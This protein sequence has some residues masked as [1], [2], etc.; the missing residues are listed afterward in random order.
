MKRKGLLL[1]IFIILLIFVTGCWNRR[2]LNDL[3]IAVGIAIDKSGNQYKVSAQVV[4]PGEVSGKRGGSVAP[5]T[6]YQATGDTILEALR[7]MT[8]ISPRKIYLAH[9]RILVLSESLAR[10]GIRDSLDLMSREPET[11]NDYFI[12]VAKQAMA[13]DMLKILTNLEKVPSIRLFSTLE[14]SAKQWAPTTTVNL[15]KLISELVSEGRHP[16]LTG[17]NVI[18]DKKIGES[19]RN[20]ETVPSPADMQYSGLAVFRKDKLI[21]WLSDE[22]GKAY[23][24]IDNNI[25]STVGHVNCP[26]GGKLSLKVIRSNTKVKGSLRDEHPRIHIEVQSEAN[27]GEVQCHLDLTKTETIAEV[28]KLADQ[29][30][31]EFIEKTIKKM[32]QEYKIDIFGFGEVIRRS[33]PKA[34][35]K[36]KKN[37]DQTFVNIPVNVKVTHK[38]PYLGKISNSF[39][40]DMKE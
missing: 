27:V 5:V 6:L 9:I 4:E 32:Q 34:W 12:V 7:Q 37:W 22:E 39:L 19:K 25:K 14:T 8:T 16:V 2:E 29:K 38:I 3:A 26:D 13:E 30:T 31:E 15:D 11:R 35:K 20:V 18:G 33:Y 17:L 28:E 1:C 21:G 36:L 23:N 40:E 10:E 24:Y